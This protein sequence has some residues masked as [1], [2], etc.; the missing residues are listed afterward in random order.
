LLRCILRFDDRELI[1]K[2]GL[3]A[4]FYLRYLQTLLVIFI[5]IAAVAIPVLLPLNYVGG[6][7]QGVLNDKTSTTTGVRG[8]APKGLD[9][10][11]WGN[12][13]PDKQHRRWA[14][15]VVALAVITWVSFI[16]FIE[17]R[18]YVKIRQDYL[19]SPEHRM[20][21]SATTVLVSSIPDKW[22]SEDALRNLFDVFPGGVGN[23]WLA[24]DF[25]PLLS[26]VKKRNRILNQLEAAETKL[27]SLAKRKQMAMEAGSL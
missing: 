10:L 12:I 7:G 18:V 5:P 14:H 20:R 11:A 4:Y 16:F 23:I 15:L 22:L 17:L 8:N 3:D 9:T 26:K 13:P 19:T 27:I 1:K 6:L 2:C 25:T 24:R 21:A